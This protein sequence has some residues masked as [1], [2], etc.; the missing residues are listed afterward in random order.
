M[1]KAER[2]EF[3]EQ[4]EETTMARAVDPLAGLVKMQKDGRTIHAHP[5]TTDDHK[6]N[7]WTVA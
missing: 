6:K 5:T 7:G 4:Q 3:Q 2:T 1:P